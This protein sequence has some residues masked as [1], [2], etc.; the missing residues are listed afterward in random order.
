MKNIA[1]QTVAYNERENIS[2]CIKNWHGVIDK[3][4]VLVPTRPWNGPRVE[5][6]GTYRIAKRT[7]AEVILGE[8]KSE[9]EQRTWGLARLYD[10]DWVLIVDPDE[11][12]TGEDQKI[13]IDSLQTAD[14]PLYKCSN[15]LTYWKTSDYRLDPQDSVQPVIAVNPKIA[16]AH[17]HRNFKYLADDRDYI[18]DIG[19]IGVTCHHFSWVKSDNKVYEKINSYSHWNSI[20]DGWYENKW[21]LWDKDKSIYDLRPYGIEQ[22]T[23]IYDP[24]P[25]EITALFE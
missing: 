6:D 8:W 9:E 15:I 5:D 12:Y 17:D 4:L 20:R 24:A 22:S 25:K 21:K 1:I 19:V 7:N 13:I 16:Y 18:T 11:F 10:Y 2:A 14:K 3:H 23:A